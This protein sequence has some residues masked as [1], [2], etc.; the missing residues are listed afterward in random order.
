VPTQYIWNIVFGLVATTSSI[1][2]LANEDRPMAVS[3]S[4]AALATATSPSGCTAC[5]PVGEI[6]TGKEMSM[7]IT[8]VACSRVWGRFAMCGRKPSSLN[9]FTLSSSVMPSSE[10]ATSAR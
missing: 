3:A 9:A 5:T 2:L 8:R 1:G 6:T 7:P 10:P 4:A